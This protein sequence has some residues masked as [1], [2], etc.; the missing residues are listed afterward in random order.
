MKQVLKPWLEISDKNDKGEV[1]S[2][3]CSETGKKI[4][5]SLP[6]I[7]VLKE[8]TPSVALSDFIAG[9]SL[10]LVMIPQGIAFSI[11]AQLPPQIGLYS[12]IMGC[13]T[14]VLFGTVPGLSNGPATLLCLLTALYCNGDIFLVV[15]QTFFCGVFTAALGIFRLGFVLDLISAPVISGFTS[16]ASIKIASSQIDNLLGIDLSGSVKSNLDLGVLDTYIDVFSNLQLVKVAD[17]ILGVASLFFLIFFR[18]LNRTSWFTHS[19]STELV[20]CQKFWNKLGEGKLKL[21]KGCVW[22]FSTARN[23]ILII[24]CIGLVYVT[25]PLGADCVTKES[26]VFS[27]TGDIEAGVPSFLIPGFMLSQSTSTNISGNISTSTEAPGHEASFSLLFSQNV[28]GV[29]LVTLIIVLQTIAIAKSFAGSK[30]VD[31]NQE[32]FVSGLSNIAGAFIQ[33][34]PTGASFSRSAVFQASGVKTNIANLYGGVVV[35]LCLAVLMP[36]CALIPKSSLAAVIIGGVIFTVEYDILGTLWRSKKIDLIPLLSTFCVCLFYKL[37]AGI[38][39]GVTI[40]II[41]HLCHTARPDIDIQLNKEPDTGD[42]YLTISPCQT[43]SFHAASHVCQKINEVIR[44]QVEEDT[45]VVID[46]KHMATID[47]TA[48]RGLKD[49]LVSNKGKQIYWT[50]MSEGVESTLSSLIGSENLLKI[51]NVQTF[52]NEIQ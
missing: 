12:S 9:I 8:Y 51:E 39:V 20:G 3:F 26:C 28:G 50:N 14:Y 33:A 4:T 21:V 46:C 29:I 30:T 17:M 7:D 19:S 40:Q 16:A 42:C 44:L 52:S 47:F 25:E 5:K 2:N 38:V 1:L 27:L 45:K 48:A 22:F 10:G 11:V 18:S 43:I 35:I 23:A 37:E 36:A 41:I 31:T 49:V 15:F 13:F 32:L 6:I 24:L 34:F